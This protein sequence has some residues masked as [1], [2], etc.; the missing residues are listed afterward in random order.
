[1]S[2][3]ATCV[4]LVITIAGVVSCRD[5]VPS[6]PAVTVGDVAFEVEIAR[7]PAV[8]TQGLSD[9]ESLPS[10]AGM[11]FVF[12]TVG[13]A[14][15]WMREM[16]FPLDIVWIGEEC[17]VVDTAL[18]APPPAPGTPDSELPR[19]T[20]AVPAAYVLEIN[21]GE[22]EQLGIEIGDEV[23]FSGISTEGA[24]C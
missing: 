17:T 20:S 16:K 5:A 12:R 2:L 15:M 23:R 9:R 22:V 21:A 6:A 24:D 14:T 10:M 8:R 7:T 18:N 3:R 13:P 11:L 19:Y 1:M 4:V